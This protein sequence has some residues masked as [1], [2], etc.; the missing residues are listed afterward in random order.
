MLLDA[1]PA[2]LE[3]DDGLR[4]LTGFARQAAGADLIIAYEAGADG[5]AMPL[6]AEPGPLPRPFSTAG[7]RLEEQDFSGGPLPAARIRLPS[8]VLAALGR[9]AGRVYHL[10]APTPE[11]P[12]SG[13][14]ML[15]AANP[16]WQC[17]CPFRS[18]VGQG[19]PL[20]GKVFAQMLAA[21][22]AVLQR[23]QL[24]ERFHDL[25]ESVHNGI[26]ILDGDGST[27]LVN[28]AAAQLLD[29]PAG[30]LP[31]ARLAAAMRRL[32]EGAANGAELADTYAPLQG[33]LNYALVTHWL[34]GERQFE[35]DTHPILGDGRQGRIWLFA[36]VTAQRRAQEELRRMAGT[37]PLTGLPNRRHFT[38]TGQALLERLRAAGQPL[39]LLML[40][41]DHFKS[42]NDRFGHPVGD[43]VL[44]AVAQR[45]RELMRDQQDMI[46]RLGGEEFAALLPNAGPAETAAVAERLR[47]AVAAAPVSS[48][49]GEVAVRVSIGGAVLTGE[50]AL[51]AALE[52]A[53]RAL[54]VSKQTGRDR[55]SFG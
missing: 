41:I 36:D 42:I 19:V 4:A 47:A 5:L 53:D 28:Q 13:V 3:E 49:G 40:D 7:L 29:L 20:L 46:A 43:L 45:C 8:A 44:Q 9:P 50:E 35:V 25:F 12:R 21:R 24:G 6:A 37:D 34:L 14:L 26:A 48:P 54:Y 55:F 11:A 33:D 39:G 32:R 2:G 18:G 27:A 22:R 30:E 17:D 15:Y 52:R 16:A 38:A 51:D 1:I 10:A 23:R 31:A